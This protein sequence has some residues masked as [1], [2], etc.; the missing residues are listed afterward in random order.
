MCDADVSRF[1]GNPGLQEIACQSP[2]DA[3][4]GDLL[5]NT[6]DISQAVADQAEYVVAPDGIEVCPPLDLGGA[7]NECLYW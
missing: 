7:D 6:D 1:A 4:K 2:V 5:H 3:A